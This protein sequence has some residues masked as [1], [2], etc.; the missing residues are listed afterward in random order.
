MV[1]VLLGVSVVV[2]GRLFCLGSCS[3][4]IK[5]GESK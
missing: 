3:G 4:W 2:G 1:G 5:E